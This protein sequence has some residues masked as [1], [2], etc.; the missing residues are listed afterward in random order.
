MSS[1]EGSV[2]PPKL[3]PEDVTLW[4]TICLAITSLHGL[5]SLSCSVASS[6]FAQPTFSRP[7]G[8]ALGQSK[9]LVKL[10]PSMNIV[11]G[12]SITWLSQLT[13]LVSFI[14]ADADNVQFLG[15]TLDEGVE[16]RW[17]MVG[18]CRDQCLVFMWN[19]SAF[20]PLPGVATD[21]EH[22]FRVW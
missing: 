5:V 20:S 2:R 11:P 13:R 8:G 1:F 3:A 12:R 15:S 19:T 9:L 17:W 18:T 14:R 22:L 10:G 6:L 16:G 4:A 7:G 21:V